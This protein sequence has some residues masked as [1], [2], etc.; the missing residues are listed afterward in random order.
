MLSPKVTPLAG[1]NC[2]VIV[3]E[4]CW[5]LEMY[6]WDVNLPLTYN[7]PLFLYSILSPGKPITRLTYFV[8][9]LSIVIYLIYLAV[10]DNGSRFKFSITDLGSPYIL[11]ENQKNILKRLL[12]I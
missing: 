1:S 3:P 5:S 7:L 12:M 6:D 10:L 8:F 4:P 11:T 9:F 2:K